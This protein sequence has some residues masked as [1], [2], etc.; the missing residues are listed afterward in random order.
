MTE[1]QVAIG[2][3]DRLRSEVRDAVA[4]VDHAT[5]TGFK[6]ADGAVLTDDIRRPIVAMAARLEAARDPADGAPE[7]A[8]LERNPKVPQDDWLAFLT[9]YQRLAQLL[10]PV[11][12]ATLRATEDRPMPL[13]FLL[14]RSPALQFTRRLWLWTFGFAAF[15]VCAAWADLH[16]AAG[17][18]GPAGW[19]GARP[20]FDILV[21]FAYGGL[22]ACVYL[23]RSAHSYIADRSFDERRKPEYYSRIFL[24][25]IG[26]GTIALFV[27]T[28]TADG[29]GPIQLSS[30]ALGFIAG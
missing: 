16:W 10:A 6:A 21:P 8:P 1:T 30:A 24:G 28:V 13:G 29:G 5:R 20:L 11:S 12:A 19:S 27:D 3:G 2:I 25:I 17:G 26:G 9:A 4:L 22:G 7:R 14:G 23:L 18:A 15:T